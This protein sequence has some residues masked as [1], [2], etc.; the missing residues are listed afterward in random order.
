MEDLRSKLEEHKLQVKTEIM[1]EL[2]WQRDHDI[3]WQWADILWRR[4][5][6][7]GGGDADGDNDTNW[8]QES[9]QDYGTEQLDYDTARLWHRVRQQGKGTEQDGKIMESKEDDMLWWGRAL[10]DFFTTLLVW[11]VLIRWCSLE[12]I[13]IKGHVLVGTVSVFGTLAIIE[14]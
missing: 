13:Y 11:F 8:Q 1:R 3:L 2:S 5:R 4:E 12:D 7:W 10:S 6:W 14:D 9:D